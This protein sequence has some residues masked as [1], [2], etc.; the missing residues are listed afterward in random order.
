VAS[1]AVTALNQREGELMKAQA[2]LVQK[3]KEVEVR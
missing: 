3:R 2:E 1:I